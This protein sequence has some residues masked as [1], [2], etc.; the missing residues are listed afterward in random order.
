VSER[1]RLG[2]GI[3]GVAVALGI[4]GDLLLRQTP[5]G[6]NW[7]LWAGAAIVAATA[8][9]RNGS[10]PRR[11][12]LFA[13]ACF[14]GAL[15]WR[16]SPELAALDL[17]AAGGAAA[18]AAMPSL[19]A[20]F[21]AH[22]LAPTRL[23]GDAAA[24]PL[25]VALNDVAW[26]DV[27]RGR[28]G[29]HGRSVTV[30]LVVAAPLVFLFGGL[31]FAADAVFEDLVR[32]TFD[33]GDPLVHLAVFAL[34]TWIAC[35]I[36]RHLLLLRDPFAVASRWSVG[37]TEVAI[38]F[39]ALNVLFALFVLIQLRYLF[40]GQ[41]H[42]LET[43]GLTYAD[44]ARRGFFE[45][46]AVAALVLPVVLVGDALAR[47]RRLF[48]WLAASLIALLAIVM[49]SALQRMRL[50]TDAYGLTELRVYTTAFML[51]LAV[52]FAW[53]LVTVL[54]ERRGPFAVGTAVIMLA[55]VGALNVLNP[56]ALIAR[57]NLDR[58]LED[59]RKLDTFYLGGL[60]ADATPTIV[61]RLDELDETQRRSLLVWLDSDEGDWRTWNW[62]RARAARALEDYESSEAAVER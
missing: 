4:L 49:A 51:A 36:L 61:S 48:R 23:A 31:F 9:A 47:P 43:T 22:L 8:L 58:H 32:D 1:T 16:A 21:L 59:G 5:W 46:V 25:P 50:Y 62:G 55:S 41:E 6:V 35:G 30:G 18:L 26:D 40:G 13:A 44:Y 20:G 11:V 38:V 2:L 53:A 39:G 24:G 54:R 28:L 27:P 42:V 15:A 60:S 37:A 34:W 7:A 10:L 52:V 33:I 45:L 29:E 3:L 14:S 57:V 12:P 19:R 56:D 17:L